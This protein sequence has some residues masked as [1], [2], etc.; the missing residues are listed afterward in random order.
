MRMEQEVYGEAGSRDLPGYIPT[1][2]DLHLCDVYREWMHTN[3]CGH[4]SGGI[5]DDAAWKA[6]WKDLS[7]IPEQCY[8]A[9]GVKA[10]RRFVQEMS[11]KLQGVQ[12]RSWNAERSIIFQIVVLK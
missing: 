2:E 7:V 1:T 5:T 12:E 8:D 6:R 9:M 3:N 11:A 10:G 4:L